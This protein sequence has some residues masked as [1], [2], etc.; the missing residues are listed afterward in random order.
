MATIH[1][2]LDVCLQLKGELDFLAPDELQPGLSFLQT[3]IHSTLSTHLGKKCT[4]STSM[5]LDSD[6]NHKKKVSQLGKQSNDK[7]LSR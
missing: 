7:S 6:N 2:P 3:Q 5:D 1:L 4:P